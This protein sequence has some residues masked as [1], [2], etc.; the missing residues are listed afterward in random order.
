MKERPDETERDRHFGMEDP[1][2]SVHTSK[3]NAEE[4]KG[5][6]IWAV[7]YYSTCT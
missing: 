3:A 5:L 7:V 2:A 4:Y 6:L 1:R